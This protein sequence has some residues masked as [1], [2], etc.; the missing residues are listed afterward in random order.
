[1]KNAGKNLFCFLFMLAV[2]GCGG[3]GGGDDLIPQIKFAFCGDTIVDSGEQCDDGN[4]TDNDGCSSLCKIGFSKTFGGTGTDE[5]RSVRQTTDGG[6]I[7]AGDTSSYGAIIND[8]WVIKIDSSGEKIWDKTFRRFR[9]NKAYSIEQTTDG[10][11]IL[12]GT[13]E[14]PEAGEFDVWVMKLDSSGESQWNIQI[15]K[16]IN[17]TDYAYSIQQTTDG[18]FIFAGSTELS[19]AGEPDIWVVK[20]DVD[21]SENSEWSETYGGTSSDTAHSIQQ[22]ADNGY[23]VAGGTESYGAGRSD[24]WILKLDSSGEK[25]WDKTFGWISHDDA[26]SIQQT[27]DGGY[28]VAG[29]TDQQGLAHYQI[30]IIKLDSSGE[31]QWDKTFGGTSDNIAYSIQQT[32]DGGYIVAGDTYF[33]VMKLDSSGESQWDER[34]GVT[35]YDEAYSIQQTT[36]GG[37][38]VAGRTNSY[39]AGGSD[40]WILKLDS[41]GNCNSCVFE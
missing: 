28:I 38:I 11:F 21:E 30:W 2:A 12:A 34:F 26:Y 23:I 39:G 17:T 3:G 24:F 7:V 18:G 9:G 5:A 32:T 20:L 33:W 10:G 36:D 27:T 35:S 6:Y 16:N 19:D 41:E 29:Y 14:F 15:S 37:Y 40:F 1:M 13:T 25:Q 22:T 8:I 31:K 4:T